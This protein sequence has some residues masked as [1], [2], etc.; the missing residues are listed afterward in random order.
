MIFDPQI[1]RVLFNLPGIRFQV[2]LSCADASFPLRANIKCVEVLD[3]NR[4]IKH[5]FLK[6]FCRRTVPSI[7]KPFHNKGHCMV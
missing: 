2:R 1:N 4:F 3:G 5:I 6:D 7:K